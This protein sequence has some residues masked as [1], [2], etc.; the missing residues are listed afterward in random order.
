[1]P[2]WTDEQLAAMEETD[3]SL[4][5]SAAAGSGKT[6]VLVE[7]VLRRLTDA[8]DPIDI[9]R[10]LLVT[11]TN[12]AAAEMRG[13]I[14]DAITA[15]LGERPDD[16]RLR[17]Q[18]LLVH[19]AQITTVHSFC[20]NLVRE[21]FAAL[22]LIPDFRIADEGELADIMEE[23]MEAVLEAGYEAE[24]EGFLALSD[25]LSA[26][27][28]DKRLSQVVLE[29]FQ[30]IQ[31]HADPDAFLSEVAAMFVDEGGSGAHRAVLLAEA[32]DAAEYGLACLRLALG[33]LETDGDLGAAYTPA[34]TSDEAHARALLAAIGQGWDAAVAA[35]RDITHDRLG[36]VRGYEDK[37]F[38]EYV[39]GLRKGWRDAADRIQ[40][41]LLAVDSEKEAHDRALVAPA[42]LALVRTVRAF[43]KAFADEKLRRGVV[44]FGDL[45]HFAVRLLIKDGRPTGLAKTVAAGFDEIMV[46]EYQ[47]TNAVQEAIFS[48]VSREGRNLFF[49]GDVKQS[50][51]G[52]RLANPYIFL[53]K[54]R[55]WPDADCAAPGEPRRLNLTR[56]FRS[57]AQVLDATNDIFRRVM[58]E[59]VGDLDYTD[60]EA[61]YVGADYPE[62]GDPRYKTE[63]LLLDTSG[64]S[65]PT[66]EDGAE[67]AAEA[68]KAVLEA[69]LVAGRIRRLLDEGFP[70]YDRGQGVQRPATA[71]DVVI[72]LR[73][74][75]RKAAIYRQ[76]LEKVGLTAE[77]DESSGLLVTS[78]VGAVVSLL[79][80]IDNPRQ[81]VELIGA[82]RSPLFGFSEQ[83]L[84]EIRLFDK[85][86]EFY[87]ALRLAA[88][89]GNEKAALFLQQLAGFRRM[90]ADLPVC[91]LIEGLYDVTGALGLYGALPNGSQRQANLLA[92]FERA[93]A[94]EEGGS[95]GLFRFTTLLRGMAGRGED[96][97]T[98]HARAGGGAV[99]ILSIHKSKGLEFPVV[100]LADCAKPFNE[101]DLRAPVL[102]HPELGL[103][104]KCRDLA[105]GVQYPT[106]QRQAVAVRARR[107]AVSEELRVLYVALTRAKEK[108]IIT[109]ASARLAPELQKWA[110]LARMDKLPAYALANMRS[111]LPWILIPLLRH[112]AAGCLRELAGCT[113]APDFDAPDVFDIRVL[114][115]EALHAPEETGTLCLPEGELPPVRTML[116][117]DKPYLQDIPAKLTATGVKRGYKAAEAAE[118][119]PAPRPEVQ[120][121]QPIF[122]RQARGLTP[123]ER[124]TAH[125][126]FMQ[127]C[128]FAACAQPGGVRA[129]LDRLR[130]RRILAPEQADAVE[131]RRIESFFTSRL[132]REG[133][134]AAKVRREFKF[135]VVVPAGEY[136]PVAE[137]AEGETVL[138]QGVID[139]L[140]ETA[141]GFTVLDFKTDR[142]RAQDAAARAERY[143]DQLDAYARAV[144]AI[145]EKPV[146]GRVLFFLSA[147]EAVLL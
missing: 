145:F 23:T 52:F 19:R 80:V 140:L 120:L 94:F 91:T 29:V 55:A 56:N 95:R 97:Q 40:T 47:D 128:D 106:V 73:S 143:R 121:R 85:K 8:K 139:C 38:Q 45:E 114:I 6:A 15:R 74:V 130:D 11:Y 31:S 14:A 72:L 138:L 35:A 101:Q 113:L 58:C 36:T 115:P 63:V 54:Y 142:V 102:V 24:D 57:R 76:A 122:D 46:D 2:N 50:I 98:V 131:V 16:A 17:R 109:A 103:G 86:A 13:K 43:G 42:M 53:S 34:F 77:T 18:L 4:L 116:R 61:L 66:D 111:V 82:L 125:H 5:V 30:K 87:D 78:E 9:D 59:A 62:P 88:G 25:L 79:H 71:G 32:K 105:R 117:Y 127:F 83:E 112:P 81:D 147:G 123:A 90:A 67:D 44:D 48:A 92:F 21:Q 89:A 10:F 135:S 119:A 70:V 26:G 124:G 133:F 41:R 107:E 129:E 96:W 37:A 27:R 136:Y 75:S 28:D 146:V 141:E 65:R 1:M 100:V 69:E 7:R 64:K 3:G 144:E 20:L 49:V 39:K 118:D 12:A 134:A 108:L 126:L 93:R 104:P 110:T 99:R 33:E 51:Y 60:R 22:N 137:H 68:D 84:A 132:Y